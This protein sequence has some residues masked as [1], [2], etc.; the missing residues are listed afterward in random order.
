MK[1][2]DT[3]GI[4]PRTASEVLRFLNEA[5]QPTDISRADSLLKDD[6]DAGTGRYRIGKTVAGRIIQKRK[7]LNAGLFQSLEELNGI[8]GLGQDKFHDLIYSFHFSAADEFV[9]QMYADVIGDQWRLEHLS[10]ITTS[11]EE[12]R[13]LVADPIAFQ[14]HVARMIGEQVHVHAE[15]EVLAREFAANVLCG[16]EAHLKVSEKEAGFSWA[17]WFY[18]MGTKRWFGFEQVRE[19]ISQYFHTYSQT[20]G[21]IEWR[22]FRNFQSESILRSSTYDLPVTVNYTEQAISLWRAEILE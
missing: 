4:S 9:R 18:R 10:R 20:A 22:V 6:P 17:L 21:Q 12:F 2:L 11:P 14:D 3:G 15:N 7:S 5:I 13:S 19:K 1:T 16:S 8:D